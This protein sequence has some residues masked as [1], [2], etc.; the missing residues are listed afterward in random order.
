MR[1]SIVPHLTHMVNTIIFSGVVP[2]VFK[3]S[4]IL[5]ISKPGKDSNSIESYRPINNL[6]CLEKILEGH[7]LNHLNYFLTTNQIIN[8]NH[9]GGRKGHSTTTALTQINNVLLKNLEN[10]KISAVLATDLSAAYDT[11]DNE[12]LLKKLEHYGVR[13]PSLNLFTSYLQDRG[14]YVEIDTFPSSIQKSLPCSCVQGSKFSGCL[15]TLY[16]N[17]IPLLYKMMHNSW[18]QKLTKFALKK[19]KKTLNIPL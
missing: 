17:E 3:I 16:T 6:P 10:N 14:Q 18:Y 9:H 12:I 4:R 15:Y 7:I 5:P 1:K 8:P 2:K 19:L 13:G 11:I